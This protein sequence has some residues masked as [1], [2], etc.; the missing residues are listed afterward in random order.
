MAVAAQEIEA[1][2]VAHKQHVVTLVAVVV[3]VVI[4]VRLLKALLVHQVVHN[5]VAQLDKQPVVLCLLLQL[6]ELLLERGAHALQ[7]GKGVAGDEPSDAARDLGRA[8]NALENGGHCVSQAERG[9][10]FIWCCGCRMPTRSVTLQRK[11]WSNIE[12]MNNAPSNDLMF[13]CHHYLSIQHSQS[14]LP[15]FYYVYPT[16]RNR[17]GEPRPLHRTGFR[18]PACGLQ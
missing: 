14:I 3:V 12:S 18:T 7:R 15:N 9:R 13:G 6:R 17:H 4:V 5:V 1:D 16:H 8:Q 10:L 2:P 11:L